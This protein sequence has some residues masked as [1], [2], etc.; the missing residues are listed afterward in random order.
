MLAKVLHEARKRKADPRGRA[1]RL[2][3]GKDD[4]K[5]LKTAAG[6]V[7]HVAERPLGRSGNPA[8]PCT[9]GYSRTTTAPLCARPFSVGVC[10]VA[11][12]QHSALFRGWR[13]ALRAAGVLRLSDK[14]ALA[15]DGKMLRGR[16]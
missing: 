12:R 15:A 1:P 6:R 7:R 14:E 9:R 16:G 10:A 8:S 13:A 11:T 4:S 5:R 2:P 3:V